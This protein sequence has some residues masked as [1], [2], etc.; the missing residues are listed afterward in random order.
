[1][2]WPATDRMVRFMVQGVF[3]R[4]PRDPTSSNPPR[5]ILAG[6][7]DFIPKI[8]EID[9]TM[10]RAAFQLAKVT[11]ILM[12]ILLNS[13]CFV[14]STESTI[15]SNYLMSVNQSVNILHLSV[16]A[17]VYVSL[18]E[19]LSV[20]LSLCLSEHSSICVSICLCLSVRNFNC[21]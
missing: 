4:N 6:K 3:K 5:F 16:H 14:L 7:Y 8:G 15:T 11:E 13:T 17:S 18:Y 1:M 20:R 9:A 19:R 10:A 2:T 12:T 21:R